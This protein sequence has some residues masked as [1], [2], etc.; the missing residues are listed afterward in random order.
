MDISTD[1][2]ANNRSPDQSDRQNLTLGKP[3]GHINRQL[4]RHNRHINRH[5]NRKNQQEQQKHQQTYQQTLVETIEQT[6]QT[7]EQARVLGKLIVTD[8]ELKDAQNH[9]DIGNRNC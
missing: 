4:N 8:K 6:H 9:C 5:S 1:I 2:S 3:E 7:N